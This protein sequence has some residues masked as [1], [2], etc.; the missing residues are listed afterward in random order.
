MCCFSFGLVTASTYPTSAG[1]NE[2]DQPDTRPL[3]RDDFTHLLDVQWDISAPSLIPDLAE[4]FG[5]S[6]FALLHDL[7]L[8]PEMPV[9]HGMIQIIPAT[10]VKKWHL[11][12]SYT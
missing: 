11:N 3:L 4:R 8:W 5:C 10:K 1:F 9:M 6:S 7:Q 2:C 12:Y